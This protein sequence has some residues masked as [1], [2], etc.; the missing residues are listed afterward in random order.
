MASTL[1]FDKWEST[2][3]QAYGTVLQVAQVVKSD[4]FSGSVG[5]QW[6]DIS[7]MSITFTP[8]F[9]TSKLLVTVDVKCASTASASVVRTR[10]LRDSNPVYVGDASSNRPRVLST[11]YEGNSASDAIYSM[12]Q[13]GGTFL[14]SPATVAPVTYKVQ[15]GGDGTGSTVH[16]NRTQ[17]DRDTAY[18]DGRG[19]SSI[20]IMEIAQ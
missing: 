8:K 1:R 14:D 10:L 11:Y 15:I 13:L 3:G 2:L 9:S 12:A 5:A 17:G 18:Y 20:T 16:V 19:V 4:A 6:L 7:G